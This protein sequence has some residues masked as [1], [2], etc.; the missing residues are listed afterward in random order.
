MYTKR[1]IPSMLGRRKAELTGALFYEGSPC[2]FGH[3]TRYV[4]SRNCV[5]CKRL[6]SRVYY[7]R[8]K[9]R[10]VIFAQL[11]SLPRSG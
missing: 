11:S 10:Q 8:Q 4:G 9:A 6:A 3:T 2:E 7:W 1:Q 5:E